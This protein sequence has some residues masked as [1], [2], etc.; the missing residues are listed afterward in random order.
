MPLSY[1]NTHI[2]THKANYSIFFCSKLIYRITQSVKSSIA[3][4]W[5]TDI[6]VVCVQVIVRRGTQIRFVGGAESVK[7]R[8]REMGSYTTLQKCSIPPGD[9]NVY[10]YNINNALQPGDYYFTLD[11]E[12]SCKGGKRI[13][14]TVDEE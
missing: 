14:I 4:I 11:N 9:A 7:G 8:V 6:A 3:V 1:T 10:E 2:P 12:E 5:N 13:Q